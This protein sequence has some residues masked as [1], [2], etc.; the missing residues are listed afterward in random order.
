[1]HKILLAKRFDILM[2][3][4][5]FGITE[6]Y[7]SKVDD[8]ASI[9][10]ICVLINLSFPPHIDENRE[11][12]I[13]DVIMNFSA[14]LQT[15]FSLQKPIIKIY[16]KA[17]LEEV[18]KTN[19][20]DP[21]RIKFQN[22][23]SSAI[24]LP[25]IKDRDLF[26]QFREQTLLATSDTSFPLQ[27]AFTAKPKP[28]SSLL[29]ATTLGKKRKD[30]DATALHPEV[31]QAKACSFSNPSATVQSNH[32][33]WQP[34]RLPSFAASDS[35]A[36]TSEGFIPTPLQPPML[37][38]LL[39]QEP[40]PPGYAAYSSP[41]PVNHIFLFSQ[42]VAINPTNHFQ[43][44]QTLPNSLPFKSIILAIQNHANK[45]IWLKLVENTDAI[46]MALQMRLTTTSQPKKSRF[47][48]DNKCLEKTHYAYQ[49]I[50][51][52][53]LESFKRYPALWSVTLTNPEQVIKQFKAEIDGAK[54][55]TV[56]F[57]QL[58]I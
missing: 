50:V 2:C 44:Q 34:N 26:E 35:T 3:A 14:F 53:I 55:L 42:H 29:A 47:N 45:T 36:C 54:L 18:L 52:I 46:L 33:F 15:L 32:A 16:H 57:N 51:E 10:S 4:P 31:A 21:R 56:T 9:N 27:T 19:N 23:L 1:M 58:S 25:A 37:P 40:I 38:P 39:I 11:Y 7:I 49:G 43:N 12:H 6:I 20:A 24:P 30:D 5:R 22:I 48:D 41:S 28:P 8:V 17:S 13:Q